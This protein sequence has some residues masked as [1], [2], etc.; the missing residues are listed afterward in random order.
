VIGP[1]AGRLIH[2]VRRDPIMVGALYV[3]AVSMSETRDG[4]LSVTV[5][6][7]GIVTIFVCTRRGVRRRCC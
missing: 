2:E 1:N 7:A 5:S 4:S 3:T 6:L